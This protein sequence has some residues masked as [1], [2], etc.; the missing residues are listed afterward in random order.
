[1]HAGLLHACMYRLSR[2]CRLV[3]GP[4]AAPKHQGQN[5]QS[6]FRPRWHLTQRAGD[7]V[8][9]LKILREAPHQG[10]VIIGSETGFLHRWQVS[11][12]PKALPYSRLNCRMRTDFQSVFVERAF[13]GADLVFVM[14]R[15]D[16][17]DVG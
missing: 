13:L 17:L 1:V 11:F 5:R 3:L 12:A 6:P 10:H 2:S 16:G 7:S 9:G 14:E 4:T 15:V 8:G